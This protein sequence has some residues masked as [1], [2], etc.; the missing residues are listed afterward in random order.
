MTACIHSSSSSSSYTMLLLF[1]LFFRLSPN[2]LSRVFVLRPPTHL[3]SSQYV[4]MSVQS[5]LYSRSLS[6]VVVQYSNCIVQ[7]SKVLMFTQ[8]YISYFGLITYL[9]LIITH[10]HRTPYILLINYIYFYDYFC[11]QYITSIVYIRVACIVKYTTQSHSQIVVIDIKYC[12]V[13]Y[14]RM[15]ITGTSDLSYLYCKPA[16]TLFLAET[17]F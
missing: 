12:A 15:Y 4:R 16:E 9:I 11:S 2:Q 13:T 1:P 6:Q 14:I 7:Y 3:S 17:F 8:I 10:T 5:A